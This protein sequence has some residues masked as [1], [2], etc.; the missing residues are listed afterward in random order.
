MV[1][2]LLAQLGEAREA[3]GHVVPLYIVFALAAP[4]LGWGVARAF[5]LGV[6]AGRA[7]AFSTGTRNALV[8]LPL[9]LAVPGG[10]ALLP[11]VVLAQT[12]VELLAELVYVRVIARWGSDVPERT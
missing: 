8:V 10:G 5:R 11:A 7:V 9:A 12:F 6:P 1:A 4:V 2:A 3:A